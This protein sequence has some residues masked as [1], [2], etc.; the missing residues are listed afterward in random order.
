MEGGTIVE[1]GTKSPRGGRYWAR[2][3]G[4]WILT[5]IIANEMAAGSMWDLKQI[6]YVRGV[7]THLGYPFYLLFILGAWK[8]PCSVVLLVPR[9]PRLKEWAYAGAFFNYSGA[10]ASHFFVGDGPNKWAA[11]LVLGILTLAGYALRPKERRLAAA[12]PETKIRPAA[13]VATIGVAV[14]MVVFALLTL[15]KGP[16]PW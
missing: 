8:L 2:T 7:F 11:P 9:F 6:E 1:G 12:S 4:Y 13:W 15:P 14:M 10:A 3:I 16:S 5:V